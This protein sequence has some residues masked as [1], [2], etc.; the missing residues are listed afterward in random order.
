M[1]K[2]SFLYFDLGNV[3]LNFD[4]HR[5]AS[6]MAEVSGAPCELVW[7]LVFQGDLQRRVECG[8][9]SS[10]DFFEEFCQQTSTR[11]DR[12]AL[13]HA[14]SAIFEINAAMIPLIS[15][16]HVANHRMG[17]LSNTCEDHWNYI[18]KDRY[19]IVPRLFDVH[20]LSHEVQVAKPDAKIYEV[21]A[22]RAECSPD[23]VFFV[24]DIEEN[25]EGARAVGFDAIQFKSVDRLATALRH[26]GLAFNF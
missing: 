1:R 11:P 15:A 23:E 3:L 14:A 2:P 10:Q 4:H 18:V 13:S 6:Q 12:N 19:A 16:L 8:T 25:V 26:R 20:V 5:G 17:I 9:T 21:A 7:E 22:N 24:D